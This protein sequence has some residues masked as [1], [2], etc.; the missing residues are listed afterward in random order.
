[1]TPVLQRVVSDG[2]FFD[3]GGHPFPVRGVTYGT[4]A[5]RADG[6][7][8][9]ERSQIAADFE[10][11]AG[12]GINVVRTYTLPPVDVVEL[13]EASG[14]RLLAGLE[15]HDWRMEQGTGRLATRR[16]RDA[17]DAE[18]DRAL[19][20]LAGN[21]VVFAV[22]VG[23]EIPVD[24]VRLHGASHVE[25]V[26]AR[27]IERLHAG[28]P[29]LL[30]TYVN[31]PTTEYLSV[32]GQDFVAFNV[33]L[34][35]PAA[36]KDYVNRL[37][38]MNEGVP[39]IVS[40][41]GVAGAAGAD[42]AQ[43][44][45]LGQQLQAVDETG[46]AGA[47][48]FSWTDDWVVGGERVTGWRF[49]LTESDRAIKPA[50]DAVRRW[51]ARRSPA[52]LRDTWPAVSAVVCAYNEERVIDGCLRSVRASSYPNL[53]I[54]VCDD[55]ST[56]RTAEIARTH[57]VTVLS[58]ERSGLSVARNRGL[59]HASGEIVAYLDA[60]A[61][62]HPDWPFHLA[63]SLEDGAAATGG[64]NLPFQEAGFVERAVASAPGNPRQVLLSHDRAEHVPGC[65]MAYRREV[66]SELGGFDARFTT[67]G[68]DVDVCWRL[69]DAGHRI[70]YAPAAQTRHHRRNTVRR[71][72]RQQRG[73]GAAERLLAA[74][75]SHRFNRFGQ[76]RWSGTVYGMTPLLP[77]LLRPVVYTGWQGQAPYQ[78][79]RRQRADAAAAV[80]TSL[81]PTAVLA[82]V[83]GTVLAVVSP[84]SWVLAAGAAGLLGGFVA[85]VAAGARPPRTEPRPHRYRIAVAGLHVVQPLA[86][87]WG[88]LRTRP[89]WPRAN[90]AKWRGD[91]DDWLVGLLKAL[92]D[93]HVRAVP[94][95]DGRM[96]DFRGSWG[97][98]AVAY[99]NVAVVWSYEARARLRVRPSKTAVATL[100]I[101]IGVTWGAGVF[102]SVAAAT[103]VA[104]TTAVS[105]GV[106]RAKVRA[107][108][109]RTAPHCSLF[110][111]RQPDPRL[112]EPV[113]VVVRPAEV[114]A[115]IASR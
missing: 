24:L 28:D 47:V 26:L 106:L 108:I 37:Q 75:H 78:M 29:G 44:E 110:D 7:L 82:F 46:C 91:R 5:A 56:D 35:D 58:L 77:R 52:A 31:F 40:E 109:H 83:L 96:W 90:A 19:G 94:A 97:P 69:T 13:A 95:P 20:R 18:V 99:A 10:V 101:V 33:F 113:A 63:L 34:D 79:V 70:T 88:R 62:C 12:L 53:E 42:I 55:G 114:R 64:P 51:T 43:A 11:M 93:E 112:A 21:P 65:N 59:G 80:A 71:F 16:I 38:V 100:G 115:T 27:M 8:F 17:A 107:A 84:W 67:A 73:Y 4:F 103:A 92:S 87:T 22:S 68:D 74:V 25:S 98:L 111:D 86:R 54:I 105:L 48:V 45:A 30:A 39:V 104:L 89:G 57:G 72:F 85:A 23:N 14:L 9:P 3:V 61:E 66:L 102:V 36:V 2:A 49:G 76:P 6:E 50:A 81:V 15:Y 32:P 41:I 60:D 1:V